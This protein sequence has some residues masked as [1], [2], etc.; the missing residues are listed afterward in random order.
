M[1]R[2]FPSLGGRGPALF[3]PSFSAKLRTCPTLRELLNLAHL[4]QVTRNFDNLL[5]LD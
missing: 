5:Q 1:G 2:G 3:A 4:M